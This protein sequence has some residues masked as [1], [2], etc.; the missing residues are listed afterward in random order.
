MQEEP[1]FPW[2]GAG[3]LDGISSL[4]SPVSTTV[5]V[6]S[7][8]QVTSLEPWV[9]SDSITQVTPGTF[10]RG[11]LPAPWW[12]WLT[13]SGVSTRCYL[14]APETKLML[15]CLAMVLG[16]TCISS[17]ELMLQRQSTILFPAHQISLCVLDLPLSNMSLGFSNKH[18]HFLSL[19]CDGMH[20]SCLHQGFPDNEL[21]W[22][23]IKPRSGCLLIKT[24]VG[25]SH[26]SLLHLT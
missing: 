7:V 1:A 9:Y 5:G 17:S 23:C 8:L 16:T 4:L 15:H 18:Y 14:V 11:V 25:V 3:A 6:P 19:I 10:W 26:E 2:P 20:F 24:F 13:V 22:F 21:V 12:R